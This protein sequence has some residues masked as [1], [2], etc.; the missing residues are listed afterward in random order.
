[1]IG[2]VD[3]MVYIVAPI[4]SSVGRA[5]TVPGSGPGSPPPFR[6]RDARRCHA[7][8][9]EMRGRESVAAR[10]NARRPRRWSLAKARS[11]CEDPRR[12]SA[13]EY[14]KTVVEMRDLGIR[15][16][17]RPVAVSTRPKEALRVL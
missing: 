1:M 6:E 7:I 14:A 5:P 4:D 16:Q 8:S 10:Q 9:A 15:E 3:R 11:A 12:C 2:V 13:R 17:R